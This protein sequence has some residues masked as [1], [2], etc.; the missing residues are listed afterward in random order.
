MGRMW[1]AME[2]TV[3]HVIDECI[4]WHRWHDRPLGDLFRKLDRIVKTFQR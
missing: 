4:V 3:H 1:D 2:T